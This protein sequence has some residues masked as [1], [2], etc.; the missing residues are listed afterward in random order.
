[1]V[2]VVGVAGRQV[3]ERRRR[4]LSRDYSL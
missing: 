3:A 1:V 4:R 2:V